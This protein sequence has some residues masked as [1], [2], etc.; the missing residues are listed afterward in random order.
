MATDVWVEL[1]LALGE[2]TQEPVQRLQTTACALA[3]AMPETPLGHTVLHVDDSPVNLEL[4]A[5]LLAQRP[6][7]RL[8]SA[9]H[10]ALGLEFARAHL[11]ALILIDIS[12]PD[13]GG[14]E[15]LKILQT[16]P[17]TRAHSGDCPERQCHARMRFKVD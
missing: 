13:I 16:D 2:V 4:V 14:T 8:L 5:Q 1:P 6:Q 3:V 15:I 9:S 17:V 10:G 7:H 11:P 12:L